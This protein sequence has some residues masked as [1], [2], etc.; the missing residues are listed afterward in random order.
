MSSFPLSFLVTFACYHYLALQLKAYAAAQNVPGISSSYRG[1]VINWNSSERDIST[2]NVILTIQIA[3]LNIFIFFFAL[4]ASGVLYQNLF[5]S[6]YDSK[7]DHSVYPGYALYWGIV[8]LSVIWNVGPSWLVMFRSRKVIYSL[9]LLIPLL[10]LVAIAVR[11]KMKFPIPGFKLMGCLLHTKDT[12]SFIL[13]KCV[14]CTLSHAVQVF[15]IWNLLVTFAFFVHYFTTIVLAFYLDPLGCLIKILF[16]KTVIISLIF[17]LALL[18]TIDRFEF[19]CTWS[20]MKKNTTSLIATIT[21]LSV[22]PLLAYIGFVVGEIIFIDYSHSG[23]WKSILIAIPPAVL[24]F[25]SWFSHGLLFPKGMKYPTKPG[26]EL[27]H[28][29]EGNGSSH[30]S[31]SHLSGKGEA[32]ETTSL[33]HRRV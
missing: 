28:D 4:S 14:Y 23:N 29:L 22:L 31:L 6:I 25:I 9:A 2:H 27:I 20:A 21:I 10:L 5:N 11:K 7:H 18:F 13:V 15:S 16:I 19:T 1:Y 30:N 8:V 32:M 26:E 24:L 33:I 3:V 12:H 17:T